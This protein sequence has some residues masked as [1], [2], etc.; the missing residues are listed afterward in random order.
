MSRW[1][2][3]I[4]IGSFLLASLSNATV[5]AQSSNRTQR[6]KTQ[7]QSP[8]A[9]APSAS[10]RRPKRDTSVKPASLLVQEELPRGQAKVIPNAPNSNRSV[11]S[12]TPSMRGTPQIPNPSP[13]MGSVLEPDVPIEWS[14]EVTYGPLGDEAC[15]SD[16][17]CQW[18]LGNILDL[19]RYELFAGVQQFS[20]PANFQAAAPQAAAG[21][22]HGFQQGFNWSTPMPWIFCGAM[23]GQFGLRATQ[24]HLEGSSL[25]DQTRRQLFLSGGMF[26]HVDFGM[27]GGCVVDYLDDDWYFRATL[28]QV[29][30]EFSYR[31]SPC[32]ELGFRYAVGTQRSTSEE[33]VR[34]A[35]PNNVTWMALDTYRF[36]Y[37]QRF[38][39]CGNGHCEGYVGFSENRDVV[40]GFSMESPVRGRLGWQLSGNY[41]LPESAQPNA[42]RHEAYSLGLALVF[43]PGRIFGTGNR[44]ER[45]LLP[46]ADNGS[47]LAHRM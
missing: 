15:S 13:S 10:T 22:S 35:A 25:S 7:A 8:Q 20:G 47:F 18:G 12:P 30:G 19:R 39:A 27:Q 4:L 45:P 40:L 11:P 31:F 26:R 14:D 6:G 28:V 33:V 17:C 32:Q 41:L 43:T 24:N 34:G 29:R 21:G 16:P 44:Y 36:F 23:T 2:I 37:R 46:V 38:G 3:A 5:Q 9:A 42:Y 1:T